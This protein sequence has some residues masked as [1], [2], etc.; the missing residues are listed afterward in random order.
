VSGTRI[1][2]IFEG[3]KLEARP[4]DTVASALLRAGLTLF[5]RSPKYHRPRGPFCLS[6]TCAQCHMRVGGEPNVATCQAPAA[7]GLE[8]ERQNALGSG[9]HDLLRALD[10]FYREGL[11]HHH[12]MVRFK[13]LNQA[14][15]FMARRLAGTGELPDGPIAAAPAQAM[16][17]P[18]VVVGG[19]PA[20]LAA[21]L[22]AARAG[23]PPL[24]LEARAAVG[25]H[26]ADGFSTSA[27]LTPD[28][29]AA[30]ASEIVA[31]GGEI[32]TD[33]QVFGLY[34]GGGRRLVAAKVRGAVWQVEVRS[35]VLATG[36]IE[37][38]IPFEGNDL[39]GVF[40]GRGL[41]RLIRRH[42]VVPGRTAVVIG[43]T[44]DALQ[45]AAA[46]ATA[47]VKVAAVLDPEGALDPSEPP[48][49]RG[50]LPLRA[51]GDKR[52]K[53]LVARAPDGTEETLPCDLVA[54]TAVMQPAYELAAQAGAKVEY[55]PEAGGFAVLLGDDGGTTVD[56]LFAG[57]GV[58]GEPGG[59]LRGGDLAGMAAAASLN[60]DDDDLLR[61]L[62]RKLDQRAMLADRPPRR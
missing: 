26:V 45:V 38:P 4:G 60:P 16:V 61:S 1:T 36:S 3:R 48:V 57:G 59:P 50:F 10:Y 39:P 11:D 58:T 23:V 7:E 17:R 19:G 62:R 15:Q 55:R 54:S 21:A 12:L 34:P 46:L 14:A 27:S 28:S 31:K 51:L 43:S 37:R 53:A 20:G 8:V 9:E 41:V 42:G 52:V 6:G 18:L 49:R 5:S 35:V 30:M 22:S 44:R 24:V 2:L 32:V 33:A 29:L 56:W 47:D 13:A 25:G 40:A